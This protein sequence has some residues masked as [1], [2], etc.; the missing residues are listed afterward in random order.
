MASFYRTSL[1]GK[2]RDHIPASGG[3]RL[4]EAIR[5][6][7]EAIEFRIEGLRTEGILVPESSSSAEYASA[8]I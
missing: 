6:I 1:L 4:V 3:S 8:K 7:R 2:S 5:L